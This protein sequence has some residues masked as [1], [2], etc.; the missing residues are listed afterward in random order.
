MAA[1]RGLVIG[2][3]LAAGALGGVLVSDIGTAQAQGGGPSMP[4]GQSAPVGPVTV[5]QF[6]GQGTDPPYDPL[7]VGVP[8]TPDL[9]VFLGRADATSPIVGQFPM[10]FM[11][12]QSAPAPSR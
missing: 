12:V 9:T 11:T 6:P 4:T 7:T 3:V 5:A 2:A 8:R 10:A 1:F